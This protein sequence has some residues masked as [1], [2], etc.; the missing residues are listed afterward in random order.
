V[1]QCEE[2]PVVRTAKQDVAQLPDQLPDDST[3]EDIR[4]HLYVLEKL[5]KGQQSI[6]DGGGINRA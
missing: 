2:G 5:K 4:Y 3:L 1:G 6:A